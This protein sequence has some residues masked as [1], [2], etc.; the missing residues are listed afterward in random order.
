VQVPS[1][2][3]QG[4][5]FRPVIDLKL[6]GVRE[7]GRLMLPRMLG[8]GVVQLNQIANVVLASFL[9]VG[10]LGYLNVAWLMIMS[11]LVLAMAVSTAI[12]PTLVTESALAHRTEVRQL[13]L[14]SLRLI[15]FLTLPASIG[16]IVL[17]EPL[18]RLLFEHGEFSPESTRQT[19]FALKFYALGL[20]GHAVVEIADRVFYAFHDTWTPVR[21]ALGAIAMNLVLSLVLMRTPLEHGGLALANA[22]AALVEGGVLLLLLSRRMRSESGEGLGLVKLVNG[23]GK[24]SVAALF[25]GVIVVLA[26]D[27]LLLAVEPAATVEYGAVLGVCIALGGVAYVAFA[28]LLRAEEIASLWRL[29]SGR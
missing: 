6:S 11:P 29:V 14:L 5:R 20:A 25:M 2:L 22:I 7:V 18:V 4:F 8:L 19:A 17:G 28:R 15:L 9:Q 23:L 1:L 27:G 13:F 16:L 3:Q 26:R 21:A 24:I 10:S 12:F